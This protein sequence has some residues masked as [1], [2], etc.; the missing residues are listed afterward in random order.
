MILPEIWRRRAV[1]LAAIERDPLLAALFQD[2]WTGVL[3]T[4]SAGRIV[5]ANQRLGDMLAGAVTVLARGAPAEIILAEADRARGAAAFAAALRDGA[6]PAPIQLHLQAADPHAAP[7]VALAVTPLHTAAAAPTGLLLRLT[8][9][10]AGKLLQAE[11]AHSQKL[12]AVGQLAGGVAHDFNNLLTAIIG[13]ADSAL[14]RGGGAETLAD[15]RQIHDSAERGAALVRQLLA[16]GRRQPLRPLAIAVNAA[17]DDLEAVLRELLGPRIRLE[18]ALEHPG[19]SVWIDPVQFD[20]VLINLAANA[21]DAMPAGG[22]LTLRTGHLTLYRPAVLGA[23][24]APPGRYVTIELA[25][26]GEGI[27][28]DLLPHVFEPFFTT[29]RGRGGRGLGLSTVHGIVR[30]SGGFVALENRLAPTLPAPT[31][32]AVDGCGEAVAGPGETVRGHGTRARI[33]LPRHDPAE[34]SD[35]TE[36][37]YVEPPHAAPVPAVPAPAAQHVR[38]ALLVEDEEPV[39]RLAQRALARAGWRVHAAESAEAALAAMPTLIESADSP[40]VLV[41]DVV[42]PG[43][44]GMALVGAV[45]AIWPDLPV[46]LVSGYTE[47]ALRGD[48][49][50]D[51]VVF[52]PKPYRLKELL[53]CLEQVTAFRPGVRR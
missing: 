11:L 35:A 40:A 16:F 31:L 50:A 7:L 12:L 8:D 34:L 53:G 43:M 9:L 2:P 10:T 29:R 42:L 23:E 38:L 6:A 28:A 20:Q 32:P 21:R 33:W 15:L 39:R 36:P 52:L 47:S 19:R 13:A 41:S 48:P 26:T 46:V 3:L 45:R 14:E 24:T 22:A 49:L 1:G 51:G 5:R 37:P 25:D 4:D 30:Q 44:D 17:I 18:L 27:P